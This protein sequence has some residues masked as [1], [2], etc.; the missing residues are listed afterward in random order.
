MVEDITELQLL[1]E[2]LNHQALHDVQTGLPN[3]QHF[4]SHLDDVHE[5]FEPSDVVTLLHLDLDGFSVTNEGLGHRFGDRLLDAVARRLESVVA[6]RQAMVARLGDDEYAILLKPGDPVPD[7]GAL[8]ETIN[9]ELAEPVYL[10]TIGMAATA[11]IGVVQR[12]IGD[13]EPSELLRDASA[14]LRR[15]RGRGKRQWA[16]FDADT[17]AAERAELRLAAAMPGALETGELRVCYQPVVVLE[18]GR[19]MGVEAVLSWQHPQLGTMS[20][21]RC[22]QVAEQTGVVHAVGQWLLHTAAEAARSWRQRLGDGVPPLVVNLTPS[23]A[24]DPDLVAKVRAVLTQT[25]LRPAELEL[26][27]PISAMRTLTGVLAGEAGEHAEDN[28]RVLAELGVRAGLH[29]FGG[30]I[31]ALRCLA[32]LPVRTVQVARPVSQQVADDPTRLLS[33]AV[34]A[35]V[36][37]VR[38]AGINV[39]AFPVDNGE[40]AACWRWVGADWAVGALFGQ[41]S[42]PPVIELLLDAEVISPDGART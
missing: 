9:T 31:G 22:V 24:Q 42:P 20:H 32:E 11:N 26:R 2:R 21:E 23:Q 16:M 39:I 6:G 8:V 34:H 5:L 4:V 14:T 15:L 29:D 28:L 33:Q 30:G 10:D 41:P 3:R 13:T 19:L 27:A 25:G 17:D 1:T 38:G 7:I 40:Q 37:I 35:L 36:H 12:R 18:S